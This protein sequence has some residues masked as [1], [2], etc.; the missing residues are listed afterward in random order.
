MATSGDLVAVLLR[1]VDDEKIAHG[2]QSAIKQSTAALQQ[3]MIRCIR[4]ILGPH[5]KSLKSRFWSR[6]HPDKAMTDEEERKERLRLWQLFQFGDAPGDK[7]RHWLEQLESGVYPCVPACVRTMPIPEKGEEIQ[8]LEKEIQRL[9]EEQEVSLKDRQWFTEVRMS[10]DELL[11]DRAVCSHCCS[12]SFGFWQ[13][14][15]RSRS[16]TISFSWQCAP[17][18]MLASSQNPSNPAYEFATGVLEE[19]VR[20]TIGA[21]QEGGKGACPH[22]KDPRALSAITS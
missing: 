6:L 14:N 12:L 1:I 9:T 7:L 22:Y 10:P 16:A 13:T 11:V 19:L 5:T 4:F 18:F 21:V 15:R 3:W 2:L 20:A 17:L 8:R